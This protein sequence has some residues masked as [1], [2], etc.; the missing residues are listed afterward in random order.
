VEIDP[1][2]PRMGKYRARLKAIPITITTYPLPLGYGKLHGFFWTI[3]TARSPSTIPKEKEKERKNFLKQRCQLFNYN[4]LLKALYLAGLITSGKPLFS[5]TLVAKR[6]GDSSKENKKL[7]MFQ[8]QYVNQIRKCLQERNP[9]KL[10]KLINQ[11][12]KTLGLDEVKRILIEEII[13]DL[14]WEDRMIWFDWIPSHVQQIFREQNQ[15]FLI[16][17]AQEEGFERGK[18]FS[19]I[20][21]G[22]IMSEHCLEDFLSQVPQEKRDELEDDL[23]TKG[24]VVTIYENPKEVI[25]F[26]LGVPFFDNLL[27][28]VRSR[29]EQLNDPQAS[30]Y[31]K[32]MIEG[33][34]TRYPEL[35]S[36]DQWLLSNV[37]SEERLERLSNIKSESNSD[38][39]RDLLKAF[40]GEKHIHILNG[41]E[42]I[43]IEALER[44]SLVFENRQLLINKPISKS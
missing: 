38:W 31:L 17:V 21:D 36:F 37:L 25:E 5:T 8:E 35:D 44:L 10:V 29:L 13:P 1:K 26:R 24:G 33:I 19:L 32:Q 3:V 39:V 34:M 7:K 9:H 14:S 6:I 12:S 41:Q 20:E 42:V 15:Q 43:S 40:G 11:G 16:Q 23:V 27:P 4:L 28:I 30:D 18:D 22:L 2:K